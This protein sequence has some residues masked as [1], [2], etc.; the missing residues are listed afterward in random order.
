MLTALCPNSA[1]AQKTKHLMQW[2]QAQRLVCWA[3]AYLNMEGWKV[4]L[5]GILAK[6]GNLPF[7]KSQIHPPAAA[8]VLQHLT[9]THHLPE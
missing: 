7:A 3:N 5:L 8:T 2:T 9:G 4:A 6:L 1:V